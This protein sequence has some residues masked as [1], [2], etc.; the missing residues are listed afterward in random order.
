MRK[1]YAD[2]NGHDGQNGHVETDYEETGVIVDA[3]YL[4]LKDIG[5]IARITPEQEIKLA[6]RIKRGD[7]MAREEM[8]TANLRLVITIAK[9][10]QG[11]GMP[12]LDLINEGNMGLMKAVE[13]FKPGKGAKLSTYA[14]WW[15][16]QCIKRALAN[17]G[18]DV[19]LPV[20][21]VEIILRL[22]RVEAELYS[23]FGRPPTDEELADKLSTNNGKLNGK[24]RSIPFLRTLG[25]QPMHIDAPLG[26]D[27]GTLADI[28]AD[29][30]MEDPSDECDHKAHAAR[31]RQVM[32]RLS[33]REQEVL[34]LR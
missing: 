7:Q 12:F 11:M 31:L 27:G 30:R 32:E 28:M 6:R 13:K 17:Q 23:E 19:R 26:E 25:I 10:Y 3:L 24:S 9:R 33:E 8:I 18:R 29:E 22:K 15:I 4:Y 20:H 21:T 16:K 1:V 5:K 14:M 34:N 2:R